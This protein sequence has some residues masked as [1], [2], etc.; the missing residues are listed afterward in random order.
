M[1]AGTPYQPLISAQSRRFR[2]TGLVLLVMILGMCTYGGKVLMPKLRENRAPLHAYNTRALNAPTALT[3][4]K[5]ANLRKIVKAQ[6]LFVYAYWG[7]CFA[8]I[9]A[10]FVVAYLDFREVS[11]NYLRLQVSLLAE[12]ARPK[13][14]S[15]ED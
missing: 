7:A 1:S 5:A 11:R 12:S 6:L 9:L 15:L 4:E 8:L 3:P 14:L 10:L 2:V 13:A